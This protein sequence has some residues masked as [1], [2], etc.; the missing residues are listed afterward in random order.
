MVKQSYLDGL[1]NENSNGSIRT[2]K[3]S[4]HIL[5]LKENFKNKTDQLTFTH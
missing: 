5:F 3:T 1:I 2:G 4:N